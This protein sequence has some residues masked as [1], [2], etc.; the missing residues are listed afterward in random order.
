MRQS[1]L[2]EFTFGDCDICHHP[3]GMHSMEGNVLYG[4][5]YCHKCKNDCGEFT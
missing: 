1:K 2:I 5:I 3:N 4:Y